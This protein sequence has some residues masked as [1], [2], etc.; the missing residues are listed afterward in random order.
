M[1]AL[2]TGNMGETIAYNPVDG[3]IYRAYGSGVPNVDQ[4]LVSFDPVTKAV[5]NIPLGGQLQPGNGAD[6]LGGEVLPSG[7][8]QSGLVHRHQ[9]WAGAEV[10]TLQS[11]SGDTKGLVFAGAHPPV[12]WRLCTAQRMWDRMAPVFSTHWIPRPGRPR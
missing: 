11:G 5:T 3:L 12:R 4:N 6:S 2:G 10:D 9:R 7:G 1:K 8:S